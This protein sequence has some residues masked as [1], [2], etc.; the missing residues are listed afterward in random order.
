[1]TKLPLPPPS[2]IIVE[3]PESLVVTDANDQALTYIYS[4][5][6]PAGARP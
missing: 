6:E 2:S 5:M 4:R 1:V 3:N